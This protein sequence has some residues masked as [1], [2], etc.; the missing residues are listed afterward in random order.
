MILNAI[1]MQLFLLE[2]IQPTTDSAVVNLVVQ[3][4]VKK[5][6]TAMTL[7]DMAPWQEYLQNGKKHLSK[8]ELKVEALR[9]KSLQ[10]KPEVVESVCKLLQ[11]LNHSKSDIEAYKEG[12]YSKIASNKKSSKR[13]MRAVLDSMGKLISNDGASESCVSA[14][15]VSKKQDGN[16]ETDKGISET[17]T[18]SITKGDSKILLANATSMNDNSTSMATSAGLKLGGLLLDKVKLD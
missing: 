9:L 18:R 11:S 3:E 16:S 17:W 14:E 1:L 15:N 6:G 4:V 2:I 8:K 5:N 7:L 10:Q 13:F 12:A